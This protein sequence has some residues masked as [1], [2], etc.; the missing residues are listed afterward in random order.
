MSATL[1]TAS[2]AS[3]AS[4]A[5]TTQR[6]RLGGDFNTFLTLLT[7]QL[8]NQSPT[9]PLDVNQMTAQLVQFASVEQQIAANQ[10]LEQLVR[11]QQVAQLTA[12]APLMG[13]RV[14]VESDR[15]TLQSGSATLRLAPAGSAAAARVVV[16][17]ESGRLLTDQTVRL[18]SG[19]TNWTWNGR[20]QAGRSL[21]DGSYRVAVTGITPANAGTSAPFTV[22]GRATAAERADGVLNLRLGA[23]T[24]GFDRLRGL[25]E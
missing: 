13:R 3:Q 5:A 1:A 10:N 6:P 14:E 18:G 21:A 16:S 8:R 25:A 20:D 7:T 19:L 22:I 12:A 11:L 24:V 9:D 15:L 23:L 4:A 17:D 2:A